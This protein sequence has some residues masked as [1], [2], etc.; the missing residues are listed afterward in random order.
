MIVYEIECSD[1][2]SYPVTYTWSCN[3]IPASGS[4]GPCDDPDGKFGSPMNDGELILPIEYFTTN[5]ILEFTLVV[6]RNGKTSTATTQIT[7]SIH[8]LLRFSMH[9]VHCY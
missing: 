6:T 8:R 2:Y 4:A 5:D 1:T 7:I 9:E 3:K